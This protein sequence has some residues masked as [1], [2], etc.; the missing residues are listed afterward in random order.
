MRLK[1]KD[2]MTAPAVTV[3]P[4]LPF[5]RV[6]DILIERNIGGVPVVDSTGA[7]LG[8]ITESDLIT[9]PAYHHEEHGPKRVL[10]SL[11]E[12]VRPSRAEPATGRT[13]REI[14]SAPARTAS[15][16]D[17]VEV[18]GRRMLKHGIGRLPVLQDGVLVGIVSRRDL[19]R[20]FHKTDEQIAEDV[21][22][23]LRDPLVAESEPNVTVAVDDGNVVLQGTVRYARD[24]ELLSLL[25]AGVGGVVDV[26]NEATAA[27]SEP[28]PPPPTM[29]YADP[30]PDSPPTDRVPLF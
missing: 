12:A 10:H 9:K 26:R 22:A 4:D 7:L 17:D 30:T 16:W 24:L 29:P 25:A 8:V 23:A 2:V 20:Q 28:G 21:Y 15:P 6:A 3:A 5:K 1:V 14:M 27:G 19:V 18:V 13:A 11:L